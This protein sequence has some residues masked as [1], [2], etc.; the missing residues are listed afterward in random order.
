MLSLLVLILSFS[1]TPPLPSPPTL[2]LVVNV[3][4]RRGAFAYGMRAFVD[5]SS[6]A[7]VGLGI[8]SIVRSGFFFSDSYT[9]P[10]K[11][12]KDREEQQAR[13]EQS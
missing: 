9:N 3:F 12:K 8:Y 13:R 1:L 4:M 5:L 11:L 6:A 2:Q 7:L 10:R